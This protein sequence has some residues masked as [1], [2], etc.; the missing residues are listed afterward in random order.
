MEKTT[1]TG[2]NCPVAYITRGKQR[3][4]QFNNTIF[5]KNGDE[6][7]IELFNPTQTK[8]LS[9][10]KINNVSIGSGIILRPGERV[11]LERYIDD[12]K[13]FLFETYVV[14][15]DNN[16]VLKAIESNGDIDIKFYKELINNTLTTS[17]TTFISN[18]PT[19][20]IPLYF[21]GNINTTP[22][23]YSYIDGIPTT[24]SS[25]TFLSKS[26]TDGV[27]SKKSLDTKIETGRIEKGGYSNQTFTYDNSS[28]EQ[29]STW[30]SFWKI[31]PDSRKVIT[32]DDL[33]VYCTKCGRKR[34]E[35]KNENYCPK[36]G[37]KF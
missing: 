6:F 7:E 22:I 23:G 37:N 4:K 32:K 25:N 13:K 16:E 15:G 5:L 30:C 19:Y 31:L 12:A 9:K 10:I 21:S 1:I 11:F 26:A 17:S 28:F 3:I 34:R 14:D 24:S 36:C 8:V 33:V 35:S 29:F 20:H 18:Y 27:R 2:G